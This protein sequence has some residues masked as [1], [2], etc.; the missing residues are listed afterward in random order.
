MIFDQTPLI[1]SSYIILV[2][3]RGDEGVG[4]QVNLIQFTYGVTCKENND[5]CHSFKLNQRCNNTKYNFHFWSLLE[6]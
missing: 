1:L 6:L 5:R 3:N 4:Y 2:K